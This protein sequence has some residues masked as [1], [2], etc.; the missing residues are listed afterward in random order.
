MDV[1]GSIHKASGILVSLIVILS[2]LLW[3]GQA[4]ATN[5]TAS[6][7]LT[8]TPQGNVF[9]EVKRPVDW[10]VETLIS[11]EDPSIYPLRVATLN[12]SS[13][14]DFFPNPNLPV[15]PD[16]QIGP[17]PTN[18]SVPVDTA[19]AR[20]PQSVIG[21]GTALFQLAG[22]NNPDFQEKGYI[23]IFNGG[24]RSSGALAG[25]PRVK[26]YAFS[27]ATGVGLYTEATLTSAGQLVFQVPR[28]SFDSAVTSL[29]LNIPGEE[30]PIDDP[31]APPDSELPAGSQPNYVRASCPG[32]SWN[33]NG[34]FLLG[35]RDSSEEPVPPEVTVT[36]S[37][38]LACT[39]LVGRARFGALGITGPKRA[40]RNR[41]TVFRVRIR[42]T[43]TATARQVVLRI[44]GRGVVN[45]RVSVGR[46]GPAQARRVRVPLR[47]TRKGR[48]RVVFRATAAN[49][50]ARRAVRAVRVR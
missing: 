46:I 42:N 36:D 30:A 29:N 25:R 24:R 45:R 7:G 6:V 34:S 1:Y 31:A 39:G 50:S 3:V 35:N 17:P 41:R 13:S 40:V 5:E 27:Y 21:N 4:R 47:F 2:G 38:S 15:C 9:K 20:C 48:V 18:V 43:G 19:V 23:V 44:R 26:V 37:D 33:L 12:Q 14:I 32:D 16:S 11:T 49:A 8:V 22:V 28:L 10:S